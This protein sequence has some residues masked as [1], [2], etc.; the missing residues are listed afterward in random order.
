MIKNIHNH[1]AFFR[2]KTSDLW[3]VAAKH[4]V[5]NECQ[6]ICHSELQTA[7]NCCYAERNHKQPQKGSFI[8]DVFF[9]R[10]LQNRVKCNKLMFKEKTQL[11][12][13]S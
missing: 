3:Q 12:F 10:L 4:D 6:S 13:K 1:F 2:S 8:T 9:S 5:N 7:G 11:P